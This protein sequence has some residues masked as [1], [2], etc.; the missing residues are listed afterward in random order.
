MLTIRR[1]IR[2]TLQA[3]F[4][5]DWAIL[6]LAQEIAVPGPPWWCLCL[7]IGWGGTGYHTPKSGK[8]LLATGTTI[9]LPP[10]CWKN[11]RLWAPIY[12]KRAFPGIPK[13]HSISSRMQRD[14]ENAQL[15]TNLISKDGRVPHQ[16]PTPLRHLGNHFPQETAGTQ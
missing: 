7:Q 10:P 2:L 6:K 11:K 4:V 16:L 5:L 14:N 9:Y 8:E 15:K 13:H 12:S 3:S 1:N